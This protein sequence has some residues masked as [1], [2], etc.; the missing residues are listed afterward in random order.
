VLCVVLGAGEG[1]GVAIGGDL[2]NRCCSPFS[3]SFVLEKATTRR[4]YAHACRRFKGFKS[5]KSFAAPECKENQPL[6]ESPVKK[7]VLQVK[8]FVHSGE[9]NCASGEEIC[10]LR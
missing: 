9:E 4:R 5:F 6:E 8:R 1:I 7:I 2:A 3:I 10:A